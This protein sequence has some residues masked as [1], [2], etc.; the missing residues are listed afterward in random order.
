[1]EKQILKSWIDKYVRI[2]PE[3]IKTA[4]DEDDS[5]EYVECDNGMNGIIY[6][7]SSSI[8]KVKMDIYGVDLFS[9]RRNGFEIGSV[10]PTHQIIVEIVEG[11]NTIGYPYLW[12]SKYFEEVV[13]EKVTIY[14]PL[15]K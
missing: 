11:G 6:E 12:D 2:K 4:S 7:P 10:E 1:M 13:A 8:F 15:N 3:F 14:K 5:Y 9:H